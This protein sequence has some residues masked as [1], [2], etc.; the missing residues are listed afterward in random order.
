[1]IVKE[2]W[3]KVRDYPDYSV[4]SYGRVR[5]DIRGNILVGNFNWCG[6]HEVHLHADGGVCRK[7]RVHRLVARA[8]IPNPYNKPQVNHKDGIR[9][10]N[11]VSNLEWV[12]NRENSVHAWNVLGRSVTEEWRNNIKKS[13]Q[14][15]SKETREKMSIG[16]KNRN[17]TYSNNPNSKRIIRV[18]DSKVFDT[19]KEAAEYM[20]IDYRL[21]SSTCNG[22]QKTAGGYHWRFYD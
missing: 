9:F 1:M 12:T 19:I 22:K 13:K 17:L 15:I 14:H 16:Q 10:N 18:E 11:M 21:I 4:S 3:R 20:G 2:L 6:Y 5:N 7:V 8:F